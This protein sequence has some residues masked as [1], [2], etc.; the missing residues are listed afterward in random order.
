MEQNQQES[1]FGLGID[2]ATRNHLSE[3]ARWAKFLAIVGFVI[4]GLIVIG[5]LFFASLMSSMSSGFSRSN[6]EYEAMTS[7]ITTFM[8]AL[9]ILV[10]VL[11]FIPCLFLYKF[12]NMMKPALASNDQE[13]LNS[14]LQ[15]LKKMFRFVGIL[16]I[17]V[18]VFFAIGILFT[19]IGASM[20]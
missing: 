2:P 11:Y 16:T 5:G 20:M 3:A 13:M 14:S 9:Y 12:G 17:I 1:L 8:S 7:G 4:C 10:A 15:N 18:L 6:Y 19:L